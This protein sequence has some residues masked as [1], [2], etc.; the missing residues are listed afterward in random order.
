ML[1]RSESRPSSNGRHWSS[2]GVKMLIKHTLL[3]YIASGL[4]ARP[5]LHPA[6]ASCKAFMRG[7]RPVP[8]P[9]SAGALQI[10]GPAKM[11]RFDGPPV[12]ADCDVQGSLNARL[13]MVSSPLTPG[14][15]MCCARQQSCKGTVWLCRTGISRHKDHAHA[16]ALVLGLHHCLPLPFI[17]G[18]WLH[19]CWGAQTPCWGNPLAWSRLLV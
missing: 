18:I 5:S 16:L 2:F 12:E 7:S 10:Q 14:S 11:G 8:G 6:H 15:M 4:S 1:G 9:A 3:G 13:Q 17:S 19:L